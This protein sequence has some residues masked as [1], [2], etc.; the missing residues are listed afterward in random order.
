[1]AATKGPWW[2]DKRRALTTLL[3]VAAVCI[4]LLVALYVI[5][6][7][8]TRGQWVDDASLRGTAIG[9]QHIIEQANSILDVISVS[10]LVLATIAVGAIGYL[11][12][13]PI[14]ALLTMVLVVGSNVTTEALK[15]LVFS[16]PHLDPAAAIG[17]NTLPSGHTTVAVSLGVGF[18]LVAPARLRMLVAAVGASY[19]AATGVATMSAGWHRP[20][21]AVAACL[22]VGAW[23]ALVGAIATTRRHAAEQPRPDAAY[24]VGRT[25]FIVLALALLAAG[26]LALVVTAF[27]VP[28]PSTRPRLFLAYA[29]GASSVAGAALAAMAGL[30]VVAQHAGTD[31][32]DAPARP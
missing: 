24:A 1:M 13:R 23:T 26:S 25:A 8:T 21:D 14:L 17:F 28:A 15:H 30:L 5:F 22:V 20:S 4:A 32:L 12:R 19:G 9:R 16:R 7:R 11:R 10:A 31:Q 6:V 27:S 3:A 18:A 2:A 29:G